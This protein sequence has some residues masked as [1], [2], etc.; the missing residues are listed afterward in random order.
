MDY[1]CYYKNTLTRGF[2]LELGSTKYLSFE[3][4]ISAALSVR[5][6]F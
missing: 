3:C 6:K 5:K 1:R 4:L 2:H